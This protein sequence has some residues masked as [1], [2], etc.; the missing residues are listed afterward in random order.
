MNAMEC[1]RS[2]IKQL[3]D[4]KAVFSDEDTTAISASGNGPEIAALLQLF[5]M[6]LF[7][8]GIYEPIVNMEVDTDDT[9]D[10]VLIITLYK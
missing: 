7:D 1:F 9:D 6:R 3:E 5:G 10:K 4:E 2:A 8:A